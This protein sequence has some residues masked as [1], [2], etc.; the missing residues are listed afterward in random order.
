MRLNYQRNLKRVM[1]QIYLIRH[2][3]SEWNHRAE[4]NKKN[5]KDGLISEDQYEKVRKEIYADYS[6]VD[7]PLSH[8]GRDQCT[9]ASS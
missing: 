3:N 4:T 5:L 6:L 1:N 9:A 2:A 7:S 8:K